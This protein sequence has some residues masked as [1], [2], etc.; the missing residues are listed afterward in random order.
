MAF[1]RGP[2]EWGIPTGDK[3][4]NGLVWVGTKKY[5]HFRNVNIPSRRRNRVRGKMRSKIRT[6]IQQWKTIQHNEGTTALTFPPTSQ[7]L[8]DIRRTTTIRR[9]KT[10]QKS[11]C[12][13]R[14]RLSYGIWYHIGLEIGTKDVYEYPVKPA[15]I[16][17]YVRTVQKSNCSTPRLDK[18]QK[19]SSKTQ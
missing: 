6:G 1:L 17:C 7:Q 8:H 2:M 11:C 16:F 9:S 4:K 3:T 14:L 19:L 5:V 13:A 12:T 18:L 15:S 10:Q